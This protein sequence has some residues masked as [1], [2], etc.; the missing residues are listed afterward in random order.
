MKDYWS[1]ALIR[2]A[3]SGL[4]SALA[5]ILAGQTGLFEVGTLEAA[6]VAFATALLSVIQN[7]L[8][9][10]PIDFMSNVPKG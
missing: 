3:R 2:G 9:D 7:A 4:Q 6:G 1:N 10:A 8:E 5:I